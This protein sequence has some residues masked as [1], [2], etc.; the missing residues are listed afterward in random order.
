MISPQVHN[1]PL[2]GS[3]E[4]HDM[5][6]QWEAKSL[7]PHDSDNKGTLTEWQCCMC[8]RAFLIFNEG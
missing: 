7:E 4:V 1:C 5:E 6:T 2:C 3:I 8:N